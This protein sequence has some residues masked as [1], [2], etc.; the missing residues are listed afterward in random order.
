MDFS[1]KKDLDA[2]R[3]KHNTT[4]KKVFKQHVDDWGKSARRP[5]QFGLM[6]G[7]ELIQREWSRYG[8]KEKQTYQ[9]KWIIK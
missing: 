3:I 1:Y 9:S 2:N 7:K 6:S 5:Q 4:D 8:R